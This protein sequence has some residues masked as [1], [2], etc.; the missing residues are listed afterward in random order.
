MRLWRVLSDGVRAQN[1]AMMWVIPGLGSV[2]SW[3][4]AVASVYLY[5]IRRCT[6]ISPTESSIG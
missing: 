1:R 6:L 3:G 4:F 5:L 2:I